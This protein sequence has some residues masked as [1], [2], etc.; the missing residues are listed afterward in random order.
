M[1]LQIETGFRIVSLAVSVNKTSLEDLLNH[2]VC[3]KIRSLVAE[4]GQI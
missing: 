4:S 1:S 3:A 2:E